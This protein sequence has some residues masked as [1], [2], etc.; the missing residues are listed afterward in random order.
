MVRRIDVIATL[1]TLGGTLE[2]LKEMELCYAPVYGTAKDVVNMAAL[3]G[4]NL[5]NGRLRQVRTSQVRQLVESGAF[6]VDVREADEYEA[7]H[8]NGAVNIPLSQFRQRIQ[9]IPRDIP[10]YLHCRTSQRSYYAYCQLTGAG[11]RNI[12]NISGSF[13]GICLYEYFTDR[14][15]NRTPIV[16]AYNFN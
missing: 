10:V 1:I 12:W 6:I 16:T 3:V 8:L 15:E 13:L 5:L 7:G 2:D 9:E 11:Y 4:L 14:A